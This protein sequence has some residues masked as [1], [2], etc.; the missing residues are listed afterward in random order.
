MLFLEVC[1]SKD[2][3]DA[4]KMLDEKTRKI[5]QKKIEN[6]VL[7]WWKPNEIWKGWPKAA[8]KLLGEPNM[9]KIWAKN[10]DS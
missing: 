6:C 2:A 8:G 5:Y 1:R 3:Q 9:V 7:P 4:L 10:S